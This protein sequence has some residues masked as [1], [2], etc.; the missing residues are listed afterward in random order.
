[1]AIRDA[2]YEL[3][4]ESPGLFLREPP[5]EKERWHQNAAELLCWRT[6]FVDAPWDVR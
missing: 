4:E 3:L 6:R 2:V 5:C 1:M